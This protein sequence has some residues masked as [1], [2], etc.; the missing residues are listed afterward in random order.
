MKEGVRILAVD[1]VPFS[2]GD[3]ST[4]LVGVVL[5]KGVMEHVLYRRIEID[6]EDS[7]EAI[8]DMLSDRPLKEQTKVVFLDGMTF[9]GLNI[10]DMKE[11]AKECRGVIAVHKEGRGTMEEVVMRLFPRRVGLLKHPTIRIRNRVVA[12]EGI[13]ADEIEGYLDY[14]LY[15]LNLAHKIGKG[16]G[17]WIRRY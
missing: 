8:K 5:R 15:G 12:Y 7:T 10:V 3:P 16:L 11:L 4:L 9:G 17:E 6:G 14:G 2:K 1:D 13:D